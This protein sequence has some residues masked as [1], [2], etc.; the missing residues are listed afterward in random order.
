MNKQIENAIEGPLSEW[1]EVR[2]QPA[3]EIGCFDSAVD[4]ECPET[5]REV[6][7]RFDWADY[8]S[9]DGLNSDLT[10]LTILDLPGRNLGSMI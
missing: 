4:C 9:D 2:F 3:S 8:D 1:A 10:D 6:Y 5:K 7:E